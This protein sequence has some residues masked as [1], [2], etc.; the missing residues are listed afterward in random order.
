MES[1]MWNFVRKQTQINPKK[2]KGGEEIKNRWKKKCI[3]TA[4]CA[5]KVKNLEHR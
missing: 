4:L 2:E 3:T 5:V 1:M